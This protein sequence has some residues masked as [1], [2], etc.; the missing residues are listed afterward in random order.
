MAAGIVVLST[1][2]KNI[3]YC[4]T[5]VNDLA[6]FDLNRIAALV[7]VFLTTNW[8]GKGE[9]RLRWTWFVAAGL[10]FAKRNVEK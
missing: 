7:R 10:N 6:R 3:T 9:K 8:S 5:C 4:R 2:A 1:C